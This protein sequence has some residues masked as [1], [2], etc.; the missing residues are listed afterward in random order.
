MK[1]EFVNPFLSSAKLVWEKELGMSVELTS[2][3]AVDTR[4]LTED[5]TASIGLSGELVGTVLY[6]FPTPTAREIMNVMVGEEVDAESEL[7]QSALGEL[8][9]MVAGNAATLLSNAG[10]TCDITPPI[11]ISA[12]GTIISTLGRPQLKVD[13]TSAVGPMSIRI[14]L[15]ESPNHG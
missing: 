7:A 2:A 15:S 6:G 5:V 14:D 3:S 10:Y 11:I 9:N 8:A 13:F 4:F 12:A 1:Q